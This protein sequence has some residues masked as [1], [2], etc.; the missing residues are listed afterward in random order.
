MSDVLLPLIVQGGRGCLGGR[1]GFFCKVALGV[2]FSA[3][4]GV[5]EKNKHVR[6]HK[7]PTTPLCGGVLVTQQMSFWVGGEDKVEERGGLF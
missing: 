6:N 1:G 3:A 7:K 5:V 4:G 2:L